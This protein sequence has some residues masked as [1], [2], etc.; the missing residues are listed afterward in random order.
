VLGAFSR[1]RGPVPSVP[2]WQGKTPHMRSQ[3]LGKVSA[4]TSPSLQRAVDSLKTTRARAIRDR[5]WAWLKADPPA[6]WFKRPLG[7]GK[8]SARLPPLT[9]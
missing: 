2:A 1:R 9:V 7:V 5:S 6:P 8:G 4:F 3:F